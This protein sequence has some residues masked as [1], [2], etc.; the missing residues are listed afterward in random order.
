MRTIIQEPKSY[1]V[2]SGTESGRWDETQLYVLLASGVFALLSSLLIVD[3]SAIRY[4][5]IAFVAGSTLFLTFKSSDGS[6]MRNWQIYYNYV[7]SPKGEYDF[8]T[9]T[10]I[11]A[12]KQNKNDKKKEL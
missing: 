3:N 2:R 1:R 6:G 4:T 9:N 12:P 5:W 10:K 8:T 11:V 7:F